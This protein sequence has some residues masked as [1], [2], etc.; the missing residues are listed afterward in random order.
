MDVGV[1]EWQPR[2]GKRSVGLGPTRWTDDIK[3]VA[4][5]RWNL[6]LP[7]KDLYPAVDVYRYDMMMMSRRNVDGLPDDKSKTSAFKQGKGVP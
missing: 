3:R 4:G 1:L 6:E 7:T 2:T 5:S